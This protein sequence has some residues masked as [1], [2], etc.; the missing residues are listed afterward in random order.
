M[1]RYLPRRRGMQNAA[2]IIH[3]V[4]R[5][6]WYVV[7]LKLEGDRPRGQ[8]FPGWKEKRASLAPSCLA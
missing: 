2:F 8:G 5:H 6:F 7:S 4:Q 3:Q 1:Q